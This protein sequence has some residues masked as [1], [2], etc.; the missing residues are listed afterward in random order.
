[1]FTAAGLNRAG[2]AFAELSESSILV[3]E[4][5]PGARAEAALNDEG[6]VGAL[7]SGT[8]VSA[9]AKSKVVMFRYDEVRL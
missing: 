2:V 4:F 9:S 1:M 7:A 8:I 6:L 3:M 5:A